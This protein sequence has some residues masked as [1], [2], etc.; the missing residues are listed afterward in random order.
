M[1]PTIQEEKELH[2]VLSAA[3]DDG[4]V[5]VVSVNDVVVGLCWVGFTH[6]GDEA[7]AIALISWALRVSDEMEPGVSE[8]DLAGVVYLESTVDGVQISVVGL[9]ADVAV[10]RESLMC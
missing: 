7:L 6:E 9:G 3:V 8:G 5:I 4:V 10:R 1:G 2:V